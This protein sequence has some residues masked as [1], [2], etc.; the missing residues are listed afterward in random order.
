MVCG[1]W[2]MMLPLLV[3]VTDSVVLLLMRTV[4]SMAPTRMVRSLVGVIE[5][6]WGGRRGWSARVAGVLVR[7]VLIADPGLREAVDGEI[8]D[9]SAGAGA[10]LAG[11]VEGA[12]HAQRPYRLLVAKRDR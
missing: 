5:G 1:P 7:L 9:A 8:E 10:E 12:Q 11:E 2:T 3:A 6:P 4:T